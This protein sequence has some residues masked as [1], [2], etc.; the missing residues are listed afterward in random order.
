[1][2]W[3]LMVNSLMFAATFAMAVGTFLMAYYSKKA[4]DEAKN[5]SNEM[6]KSTKEM[7][8]TR[9]ESNRAN[10]ILF[11]IQKGS[12]LYL[13]IKNFGITE[14]RNV[15][16]S[17]NPKIKNSREENFEDLYGKLIHT[18]PPKYEIKS[19]FD[20]AN[21]YIS[22][23]SN[24]GNS[25]PLYTINIKFEDIYGENHFLNYELD[26]KHINNIIWLTGEDHSTEY[27][28]N[29]LVRNI[30]NIDNTVE[31]SINKVLANFTNDPCAECGK[32]LRLNDKYCPRCGSE[33]IDPIDKIIGKN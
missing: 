7:E 23:V 25:F 11:F 14:A 16:I 20:I 9:K 8:L 29:E 22:K 30:K 28:L 6:V 2:D 10:V 26:L 32:A 13:V 12:I 24:K 21:N 1:M 15:S 18:F 4:T 5:S 3:S 31:K 27:S 17:S 33:V 19:F